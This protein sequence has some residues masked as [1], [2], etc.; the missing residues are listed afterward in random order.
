MNEE[1][2]KVCKKL[3]KEKYKHYRI[4][5]IL[6]IVFICVSV[7]FAVL[8]F[9]SGKMF[10]STVVE[11]DNEVV[12]KNDGDSNTNANNGNIIVEKQNDSTACAIILVA[13]IISGGIIGGCYIVSQRNN[14]DKE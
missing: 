1:E 9:A 6:A 13:L 2:C 5:K 4:W 11:Y 10:T 3:T 8:F 7:L 12:V 14:K